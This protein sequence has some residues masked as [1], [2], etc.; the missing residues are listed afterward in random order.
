MLWLGFPEDSRSDSWEE[1][2]LTGFSKGTRRDIRL[3]QRQ[4]L[5]VREPRGEAELRQA[6]SII[7]RNGR[8]QGYATRTWD[9]VGPTLLEQTAKRQAVM[10]VAW[11]HDRAV[12]A[13]YGV[14][15]GRRYSYV[16]GGTA[17][18]DGSL[19]IGHFIHWMAIRKARELG[20]A[21]Y[22]FTSGGSGGVMRFKMGFRPQHIPF[23]SPRYHIFSR[24][25]F[26]VFT[27]S[28]SWL[29]KHKALTARILSLAHRLK[30]ALA[31]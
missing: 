3:S 25:R 17:R 2:M 22:D 29:R 12:G 23:V 15:A 30:R 4:Q 11:H 18:V 6:Y 1:D 7:E 21:G 19:R 27:R 28:Y 16:M 26:E 13:H 9:D 24:W 10:L 14:L 5:E 31:R 8:T 20:L